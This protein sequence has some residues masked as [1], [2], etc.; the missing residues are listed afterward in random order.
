MHLC[1]GRFALLHLS[2]LSLHPLLQLPKHPLFLPIRQSIKQTYTGLRANES[3]QLPGSISLG[4]PHLEEHRLKGMYVTGVI[5]YHRE[6][7]PWCRTACRC[8]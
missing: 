3:P 2:S 1:C 4:I 8:S 6:S 7:A 5:A